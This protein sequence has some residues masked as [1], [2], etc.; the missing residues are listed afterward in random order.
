M[1]EEVLSFW[2]CS[3]LMS[4]EIPKAARV[5]SSK[6]NHSV[7]AMVPPPTRYSGKCINLYILIPCST[8][9][10][11]CDWIGAL[12]PTN[13]IGELSAYY[14]ALSAYYQLWPTEFQHCEREQEIL[15]LISGQPSQRAL[16][17]GIHSLQICRGLDLVK[18]AFPSH[19]PIQRLHPGSMGKCSSR[20]PSRLKFLRFL[21]S[22]FVPVASD[23]PKG[24]MVALASKTVPRTP[25]YIA[26]IPKG[27][28]AR[29]YIS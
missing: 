15:P 6:I 29:F 16:Q 3:P 10:P 13:N 27:S 11:C 21:F 28:A 20:P 25:V 14:C 23:Q 17:Y 2:C 1:K 4:E 22:P 19:G 9:E 18:C 8:L 7:V 12:W 5:P 26:H 24:G